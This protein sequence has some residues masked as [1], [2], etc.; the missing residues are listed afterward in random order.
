MRKVCQ[1]DLTSCGAQA[2]A[3]GVRSSWYTRAGC[4]RRA[5]DGSRQIQSMEHMV[6]LVDREACPSTAPIFS[7][8]S[9]GGVLETGARNHEELEPAKSDL[10]QQ[11][12]PKFKTAVAP[13]NLTWSPSALHLA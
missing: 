11:P 8:S 10:H 7:P 5:E 9:A 3:G 4:T 6:D 13:W 12:G 1:S 2:A